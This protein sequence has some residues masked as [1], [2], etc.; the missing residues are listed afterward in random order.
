MKSKLLAKTAEMV[1][2]RAEM[3][4][5]MVGGTPRLLGFIFRSEL[6]HRTERAREEVLR[7]SLPLESRQATGLSGRGR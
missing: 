3:T 2:K 1:Q 4:K 7:V 6:A 5:I